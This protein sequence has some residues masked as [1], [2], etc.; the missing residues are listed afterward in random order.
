MPAGSGV[1]TAFAT[2]L[3]CAASTAFVACGGDSEDGPQPTAQQAAEIQ[4]LTDLGDTLTAA[5]DDLDTKKLCSYL[6]PALLKAQFKDRRQ[7]ASVLKRSI[8]NVEDKPSFDF[9]EV[10]IDGD[11]AVGKTESATG[12]LY[13][14]KIGDKWF[15]TTK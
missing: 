9:N 12:D 1:R 6:D 3:V 10:T 13:F 5:V 14:R 2:V 4:E 11:R 7:C 8:I 15:V